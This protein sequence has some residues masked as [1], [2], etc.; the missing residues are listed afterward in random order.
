ML[1]LGNVAQGDSFFAHIVVAYL[2]F[3]KIYPL[4]RG[5]CHLFLAGFVLYTVI[6]ECIY[7]INIRQAYLSSPHYANRLSSK[8]VLLTSVPKPYLDEARLRK[9]YGDS[10]KRIWIPRTAKALVKLVKEREQ[11]AMRLEKAEIELIKKANFSMNKQMRGRPPV[12]T[13]SSAEECTADSSRES[14]TA[15]R[16][17]VTTTGNDTIQHEIH[18]PRRVNVNVTIEDPDVDHEVKSEGTQITQLPGDSPIIGQKLE[19]PEYV[20]PYGLNAD[21]PD[22]RGSVAAQW[23]P[24]EARPHHRP[25]GNFGRRVDT[26]RWTRTRLRELNLMIFKMRRQVKRGDGDALPAAFIEFESQEAAQAAHQVVAHHRPFQISPRILGVR[27]D[28]VVWSSLRM[29]WWERVIRHFLIMGVITVAIV[30][31]SVPSAIIGIVSNVEFLS[32]NIIFLKWITKLPKPI[33]G[34]LQGFVPAMALSWWMALVPWMVRSM[35]TA[36]LLCC[37]LN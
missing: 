18:G 13:S 21:L 16:E 25:I 3:G 29:K 26:I 15:S 23:M 10:V 37:Y 32:K 17:S 35:H 4:V 33:L 11:T 14:R 12:S 19:D 36:S 30:F 8:T 5:S 9:L 2:F 6:R 27:P 1:T 22:V 24:A 31:W 34:F 28:E 20:H 7:Y